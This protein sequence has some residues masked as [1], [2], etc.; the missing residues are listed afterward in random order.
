[1]FI[2]IIICSVPNKSRT[3]FKTMEGVP[4]WLMA[5]VVTLA[6]LLG[7]CFVAGLVVCVRDILKNRADPE[8]RHEIFVLP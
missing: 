6:V 7:M 4:D 8:V 1:M 2:I 3:T 5:L